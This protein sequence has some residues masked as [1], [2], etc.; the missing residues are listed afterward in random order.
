MM[1]RFT[2]PLFLLVSLPALAGC[3]GPADMGTVKGTVLLGK[4]PLEGAYVTFQPE[5]GQRPSVGITDKSGNY[6]LEHT[7]TQKGAKVGKHKVLISTYAD[8]IQKEDGTWV[9]GPPERV[10]VQYNTQT[11]LTAEVKPG[12]NTIDF[13]L[14]AKGDI[15]KH[16]QFNE[17]NF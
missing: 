11:T 7:L 12:S 1:R 4:Q 6:S 15:A 5:S 14:E 2:S 13:D 10:P 8:R 16:Q 9:A 3:G 17:A